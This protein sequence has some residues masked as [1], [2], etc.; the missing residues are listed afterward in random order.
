[1]RRARA[2]GRARPRTYP[3]APASPNKQS[4]PPLESRRAHDP[5]DSLAGYALVGRGVVRAGGRALAHEDG[6]C[7]EERVGLPASE[8]ARAAMR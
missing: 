4:P 8:H 3:P 1:M 6:V 7:A 2:T 5:R